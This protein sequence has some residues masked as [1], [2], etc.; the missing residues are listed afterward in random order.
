LWQELQEGC[1]VDGKI[2]TNTKTNASVKS[3]CT[4]PIRTTA[5]C[6]TKDTSEEESKVECNAATDDIRRSSPEGSADAKTQE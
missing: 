4:D 1:S 2:A 6:K 5:C 3:A